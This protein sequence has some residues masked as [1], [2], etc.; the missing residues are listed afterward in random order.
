M[1]DIVCPTFNR[2]I[3]N[4]AV[5]YG[6][7]G[8]VDGAAYL[9]NGIGSLTDP[10]VFSNLEI[11]NPYCRD[12]FLFFEVLR[13][14]DLNP[15]AVIAEIF[16]KT[17]ISSKVTGLAK[18]AYVHTDGINDFIMTL[19]FL[20]RY[21]D[22]E[23]VIIKESNNWLSRAGL[24]VQSQSTP[25]AQSNM[26]WHFGLIEKMLG[27][28]RGPDWSCYFST[29]PLTDDLWKRCEE[30]RKRRGL[31]ELPYEILLRVQ[32]DEFKQRADLTMQGLL[33]DNRVW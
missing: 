14:H 8:N 18:A 6:R 15:Q 12:A 22:F 1:R 16:N 24:W 21:Q 28:A 20:S 19:C 27:S 2:A 3:K 9:E 17:E 31:R 11:D 32:S 7:R 5:A 4:I 30:E 25:S 29:K 33:A 23:N 26:W 13:A 10:L